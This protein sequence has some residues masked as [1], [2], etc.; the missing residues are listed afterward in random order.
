MELKHKV[1]VSATKNAN[2]TFPLILEQVAIGVACVSLSGQWLYVNKKITEITGYSV[3]E[4]QHRTFQE[5]M[6]AEG[7]ERDLSWMPRLLS[8]VLP[9]YA[10]EKRYIRKDGSF[11]WVNLK[12]SLARKSYKAP[13]FFIATIEDITERKQLEE[14]RQS[15]L[16]V[17]EEAYGQARRANEQL[18]VLQVITDTALTHLSLDPLFQAVMKEICQIMAADN[19]AVLLLDESEQFLTVRAVLGIE[20]VIASDIRIPLG[21]GFAGR[22][23]AQCQPIIVN[24]TSSV[25]ILN[26]MLREQLRSLLGVPL[27]VNERVTGVI[28][29]GMKEF[30]IFTEQDVQLLQRV[31]QRLALAIERSLLYE[32]VQTARKD[33]IEQ[34][35][36]AE[37]LYKQQNSFVSIVSHEFRTTLTGIQG[38]SDLLRSEAFDRDRV[39]EYATDIYEDSLRLLRMINELLDTQQM[40]VGKMPLRLETINLRKLLEEQIMRIRSITHRHTFRIEIAEPFPEIEGDTDKFSQIISNLLSNAVKYSPA[41]G[42]IV[43]SCIQE[44][45]NIHLSIQDQGIGIPTQALDKIFT[46]YNRVS[47]EKTRH[48]QGTG[49]GLSIVKSI[50]ELHHGKIWVKSTPGQGSIFHMLL[51]IHQCLSGPAQTG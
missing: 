1:S 44:E 29:I 49:L 16:L 17:R 13:E 47:S 31:A 40:Q 43:I 45:Q 36:H 12:F 30:H 22:V 28:H 37:Q 18:M 25:E 23:A 9:S 21:K 5:V 34:A 6:Q 24:D 46:P 19:I 48:I 8:G 32:T 42:E 10:L 41:G 26:P 51:P 15:H 39:K 35:Q 50:V 38:F 3:E 27:I 2:L 7:R 33:A 14:E 11:I 4:F 20:E